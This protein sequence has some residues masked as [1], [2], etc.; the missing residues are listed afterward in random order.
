LYDIANNEFP[1]AEGLHRTFLASE[2]REIFLA[3]EAL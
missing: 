2:D 1:D 3:V